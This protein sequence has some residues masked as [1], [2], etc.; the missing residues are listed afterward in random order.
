MIRPARRVAAAAALVLAVTAL[1]AG[2]SSAANGGLSGSITGDDG[3]PLAGCVSVYDTGYE[4]VADTCTD[5]GAWVLPE[6]RVRV[7]AYDDVHVGEWAQDALDFDG[8]ADV[9]APG[10][11]DVEL[12]RG[13]TL[14]GTLTHAQG[15]AVPD[16]SID[17][18][19]AD[20]GDVAASTTTNQSGSWSM[21]LAPG[22]YKISMSRWPAVVWAFGASSNDEATVVPVTAGETVQVDDH[23]AAQATVKG[24]ITDARTR[25]PGSRACASLV[26]LSGNEAGESYGDACTDKNGRYHFTASAESTFLV[27]FTDPRGRYAAEYSGD[28]TKARRALRVTVANGRT[29]VVSAA[30]APGGVL[31]GRVVDAK[32]GKG[33]KGVCPSAHIGRSQ[34]Y[35]PGQASTCSDRA[36]YYRVGALPMDATTLMLTPRWDSGLAQS[37]FLGADDAAHARLLHPRAARTTTLRATRLG[38]PGRVTGRVTDGWAT[39]S[40][41]CS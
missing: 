21:L 18:H 6:V 40:R 20:H 9:T 17:V 29:K 7:D 4:F 34:A 13:G 24:R 38:A 11:V 39:R 36:G 3:V 33:I 30:L 32:T 10:R 14:Q 37:W 35:V 28:T 5:D 12:A 22:E 25:Q 23:F 41:A 19:P 16:A 1:V 2:P 8:A 15:R 31:S 26:P 27:L